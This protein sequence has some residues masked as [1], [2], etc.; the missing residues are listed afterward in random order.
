MSTPIDELRTGPTVSRT[1]Y[2]DTALFAEEQSRIFERCWL[3]VAHESEFEQP[4]DFRTTDLAGQPVLA[5]KDADGV[6]RVLFNSCRHRGA[7]IETQS[8]GNRSGF[9]C[10]Y[11]HW[12]YGLDGRLS[13]VPRPEG[14]DGFDLHRETLGL[15]P[16]PRVDTYRG[17]IFATLDRDAPALIDYLGS[18]AAFLDYVASDDGEPLAVYGHYRYSYNGNWKLFCENTV[19]DYHAEYLHYRVLSQ[20]AHQFAFG[21]TSRQA[22]A[23]ATHA[24]EHTR[25]AHD[26]DPH[27]VLEWDE[28][29]AVL[30]L[31][32]RRVRHMHVGVFPSLFVL[33]HPVWDVGG[34]R[35]VRPLAVD[36]SEVQMYC[37]G[38]AAADIETRRAI[39]Q[40]F[41]GSWG[42]GGRVAADDMVAME[43]VQKGLAAR[44]GGDL[45]I[46]RGLGLPGNVGGAADEQSIR[47]FWTGWRRFM[48]EATP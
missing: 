33:Y 19:D 20:R 6:V 23:K 38:P 3:F 37:L 9:R 8:E 35:V 21:V 25:R 11:H 22:G 47:G 13:F 36:R 41:H 31:Q 14:Y 2:T 42:P 4:G 30:R 29:P 10:L 16:V 39:A 15:V 44:Q 18:A 28:E 7:L 1:C 24:L 17:L 12:E 34:I 48:A 45:L 46:S 5:V 40:R 32:N 43:A 27:S 26:L